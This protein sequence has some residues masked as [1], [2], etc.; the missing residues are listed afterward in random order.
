MHAVYAGSLIGII[1]L[2]AALKNAL[3][4]FVWWA[5]PIVFFALITYL[6][7]NL[8]NIVY[9]SRFARSR[10]NWFLNG[11]VPVVGIGLDAYLIYKSFFQALWSAGF[12]TG[13]SIILVSMILVVLGIG[14]VAYL[15][16]SAAQRLA[17]P[18]AAF[19]DE[20]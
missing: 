14:Y 7:V 9:F 8:A 1:V 18:V 4:A 20:A 19:D 5:G 6:F 17:Q 13:Q 10:F 16:V 3:S 11:V 2:V 15:K 12:E